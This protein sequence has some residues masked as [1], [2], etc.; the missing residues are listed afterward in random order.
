MIIPCPDFV[1]VKQNFFQPPAVN[2][3]VKKRL[4]NINRKCLRLLSIESADIVRSTSKAVVHII[5]LNEEWCGRIHRMISC[6][7]AFIPKTILPNFY[8]VVYH[9][10]IQPCS[11]SNCH[12]CRKLSL[13]RLL[14]KSF[15]FK[16]TGDF[17]LSFNFSTP[18]WASW[19]KKG[20]ILFLPKLTSSLHR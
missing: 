14:A 5:T 19:G 8:L 15:A 2:A 7:A 6:T 4:L 9:Y 12:T 11:R 1:G 16:K 10:Y 20:R 17:I 13:H 3:A 18:T